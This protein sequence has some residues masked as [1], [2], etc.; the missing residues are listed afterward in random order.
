[1]EQTLFQPGRNGFADNP[2]PRC[3]T[4]LLLDVSESMTGR[5]L[6]ELQAGL[7]L[8]RDD[9]AADS[10]ARKR[11]EVAIVTF[12][13]T[14]DLAHK[15]STAEH[16]QLPALA[17]AGQT[18]MAQAII[19]G[20]NLLDER[21]A[22]YRQNGIRYYRPWVFLITDGAPTDANTVFWTQAIDL[23]RKGEDQKSFSFFAVG[24]ENADMEKLQEFAR[25]SHR[26]SIFASGQCE[27]QRR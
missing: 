4:V 27:D 5:P 3:A 21:K 6:E 7:S 19:T 10:L 22:K 25:P 24:V 17:A 12:G 15:F 8:Y 14:V 2:E 18:P 11:I 13:G 1:M 16:L 26:L 9:L 23:I 20:L